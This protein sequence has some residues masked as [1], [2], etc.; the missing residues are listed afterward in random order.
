MTVAG[1][2]TTSAYDHNDRITSVTPP[3]PASVINYTWDDNGDLTARGSDS[4]SWDYE[5]RMVSA[6]V[7]SVTTTFAYRGDGLRNSRTVGGN[8]TTFTWDIA[9][10]L[11]VVLDDGNQYVYGAGLVSQKQGG[12]WYYYL[13][14][15]LGS[16]M[17]V[18][19]ASGTVQDSYTYDVYGT[20][21]KTGSLGNEFDFAG[22]Q[23]D[24]TGLQYLR[25]RYYDSATGTFL[26][27]DPMA[28]SATWLETPFA[29]SSNPCTEID[30]SG[31]ASKPPH[32]QRKC[33]DIWEKIARLVGLMV[34]RV[35]EWIAGDFGKVDYSSG[36]RR[37]STP[38]FRARHR[39]A[40]DENAQGF[41]NE[42]DAWN[43]QGCGNGPPPPGFDPEIL[44]AGEYLQGKTLDEAAREVSDA[45]KKGKPLWRKVF[46]GL[47]H[48]HIPMPKPPV[49]P[50]I[51]PPIWN[52]P[53]R[54]KVW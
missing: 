41:R 50:P 36:T 46:D 38:E 31:L 42:R 54:G 44:L 22:Q 25:A 35:D 53:V 34:D 33:D 45:L 17:A 51:G 2:T 30:P 43:R 3:S 28:E 1:N 29:Y 23:T 21:T 47:P 48:I 7:N 49:L 27:R 19:N 5:D 14:D 4:F 18:V 10:G 15:G 9:A 20:P 8:T 16:T 6:T 40:Y 13:A 52:G 37:P 12:N 26:S 39:T 24:G 11:P 32:F